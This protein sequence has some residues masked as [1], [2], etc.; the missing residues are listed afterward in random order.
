LQTRVLCGEIKSVPPIGGCIGITKPHSEHLLPPEVL[1]FEPTAKEI[2]QGSQAQRSVRQIFLNTPLSTMEVEKLRELH[3]A[4]EEED[5]VTDHGDGS[6]PEY[7][8]VHALRLLQH[9]KFKVPR[10]LEL[11]LVHLEE[12]AKR[13]PI[14][15]KDVMQ[16]LQKGF[17]YWHGRDKKCR[18]CLVIR[19]ERMGEMKMDKERAVRL[20]L[21]VLEYALRFAM[22]P[23]RV[24]NWVV[25]LDLTNASKVVSV[26]H[27]PRLA[28]TAKLLATTLESVYCGRMVWLKILNMPSIMCRVIE[29][30]IPA[31]KKKKVQFVSN[32]AE[33][34]S[35]H[36][37]PN[38]LEAKYGGSS[39]DLAPSETYPFKFFPGACGH[40]SMAGQPL[41]SGSEPVVSQQQSLHHLTTRA[42]HEGMIWDAS[43]PE[44]CG[45][46][47]DTMLT[48][49]LTTEAAAALSHITG[50]Q[51]KPCSDVAQWLQLQQVSRS[52]AAPAG[53]A[54]LLEEEQP[55][56]EAAKSQPIGSK[57]GHQALRRIISL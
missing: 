5:L 24:E 55:Q 35:E 25:L 33:E 7:V 56:L 6:F 51:V 28:A 52:A 27:L 9:K 47:I 12:R 42:F 20:V 39:S 2:F 38:Q 23:G 14:T 32:I 36:F 30:C 15:E 46:W 8:R 22:V 1:L 37:V 43:E 21:F 10:T 53:S 18:P 13:L 16:D 34:L 57:A 44:F 40:D 4:L 50:Q 29:G 17:M 31:E 3:K 48:A 11:M 26:F 54:D 49:S 19:V 41:A 45:K